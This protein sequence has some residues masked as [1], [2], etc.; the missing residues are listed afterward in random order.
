MPRIVLPDALNAEA[1][2]GGGFTLFENV[3]DDAV[4]AA[5][6]RAAAKA[7]AKL[8]EV[9]GVAGGDNFD[10][11]IFGIADP[12]AQ[13]EFAGFAVNEPAEAYS[14]NAAL[15]EKVKDHSHRQEKC[16]R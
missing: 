1:V 4:N 14:L 10:V 9:V 5:A 13:F 7:G 12:T 3:F 2:E 16:G 15:N 6:A 11:A 8:V